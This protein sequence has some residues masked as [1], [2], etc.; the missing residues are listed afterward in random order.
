MF[1]KGRVQT[2]EFVNCGEFLLPH[3]SV[4]SLVMSKSSEW[5]GERKE[6]TQLVRV[7]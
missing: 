5:Q 4:E 2:P 6:N 7:L 3:S 1:Q